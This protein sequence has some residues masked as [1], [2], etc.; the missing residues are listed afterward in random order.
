MIENEERTGSEFEERGEG[1]QTA[2]SVEELEG[3]GKSKKGLLDAFP[4]PRR[5]RIAGAI[6]AVR[7]KSPGIELWHMGSPPDEDEA[8]VWDVIL[9]CPN[10]HEF[11]ECVGKSADKKSKSPEAMKRLAF[12]VV[13]FPSVEGFRELSSRRPGLPLKI[14][15]D[16]LAIASEEE[17]DFARKV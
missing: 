11:A 8:A 12:Q 13:M 7:S 9:R 15:S 14:A 16:A 1:A 6:A 2:V 5:R 10:E 17:P 3:L 4:E